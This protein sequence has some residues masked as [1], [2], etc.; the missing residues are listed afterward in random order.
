M[1]FTFSAMLDGEAYDVYVA[2]GNP[3]AN[4]KIGQVGKRYGMSRRKRD[5]GALVM[6]G[7]G[8]WNLA[9]RLLIVAY[10]RQGAADAIE[11]D[12]QGVVHR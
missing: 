4:V 9:G 11:D 10:S 12:R 8:G 7:W 6:K 5:H 1:K 2:E 3:P